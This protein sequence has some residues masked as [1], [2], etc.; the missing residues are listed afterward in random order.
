M[1]KSIFK[2]IYM[3]MCVLILSNIICPA[4]A[5]EAAEQ[6]EEAVSFVLVMDESSSMSTSDREGYCQS[7]I[8]MFIDM[9]PVENANV[10]VVGF[11]YNN[12]STAYPFTGALAPSIA[13]HAN[14]VRNV[15]GLTNLS[16][17]SEKE[18]LISAV[19]NLKWNGSQTLIDAGLLAGVDMLASSKTSPSR[20]CVIMLTDGDYTALAETGRDDETDLAAGISYAN[21]NSWPIYCIELD[22][23]N[24][25]S[26]IQSAHKYLTTQITDR[27][28]G[29]TH[30]VKTAAD[31]GTAFM[32]IIDSFY[33][34]GLY[35][36]F[37][38]DDKGY[39]SYSFT[40]PDLTSET[41][42]TINSNSIKGIQLTNGETVV[43]VGDY[44]NDGAD[45]TSYNTNDFIINSGKTYCN[46]KMIMPQAGEWTLSVLASANTMVAINNISFFDLK[47]D[48]RIEP[49]GTTAD[50]PLTREDEITAALALTYNGQKVQKRSLGQAKAAIHI[51]N[52][53]SGSVL[54]NVEM[55]WN[56]ETDQFEGT[57]SVAD[58]KPMGQ[59]AV[60][61]EVAF[62]NGNVQASAPVTIYTWNVPVTA[63]SDAGIS[64]S[65]YVR[66]DLE[67]LKIEDLIVNPDG[68][69]LEFKIV[70]DVENGNASV[71]LSQDKTA[72]IIHTGDVVA[73]YHGGLY[74][75]DE[76]MGEANALE[77]P[78]ALTVLN[79]E[80]KMKQID[81]QDMVEQWIKEG[82]GSESALDAVDEL[83]ISIDL[84]D[85]YSDEDQEKIR[86]T[87][88]SGDETVVTCSEDG[89]ILTLTGIKSAETEVTVSATDDDGAV[90][91]QSFSVKAAAKADL[92]EA[93]R[94]KELE[95]MIWK[96]GFA[97]AGLLLLL[98]IIKIIKANIRFRGRWEFKCDVAGYD[99][100]ELQKTLPKDLAAAHQHK[101]ALYEIID[102]EKTLETGPAASAVSEAF[103]QL[104]K[105]KLSG[106]LAG[107]G[108][109]VKSLTEDVELRYNDELVKK[110]KL[111]S[112]EE[113]EIV[114]RRQDGDLKIT[115]ALF[116]NKSDETY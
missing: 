113:A 70:S 89:G 25:E 93:L 110:V 1:N 23:A 29:E 30:P 34:T 81:Q 54:N 45:D 35:S 60:W 102:P 94:R 17:D 71:T 105:V 75:W 97:V 42:I 56:Q 9:L 44:N 88:K 24:S 90:L 82:G 92:I 47:L 109:V 78:F 46:A 111:H 95:S 22:Y 13:G 14:Y 39:G 69:P 61:T 27:C 57:V 68:D 52:K 72:L 108:C 80:M 76:D 11:G 10:G 40:V 53:T 36:H 49:N 6:T 48:A 115:F 18:K 58:L 112:G 3:A 66:T 85:F 59:L 19:N 73:D 37:T 28:E 101:A 33:K 87:V 103:P 99:F 41:N 74:V 83:Q 84:N 107:T 7:A 16:D 55:K 38:T 91:E 43:T 21:K 15:R 114:V 26:A 51:T 32:Q 86:Y 106:T 50:T 116:D 104:S 100:Y 63:V 12:P 4:R 79:H 67:P 2:M 98:I 31:V 20:G 64:V 8:N 65:G 62:G 5:E 96:I 77:L